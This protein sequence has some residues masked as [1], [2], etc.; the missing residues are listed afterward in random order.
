MIMKKVIV[1]GCPGG[2]KST[3]SRK[4]RDKTGLPLRHLDM[5]W[6]RP[7]K[8]NITREAFDQALEAILHTN[9]WIID[10][11]Y[12]CTMEKRIQMCDTVFF[13][14]LPTEVCLQGALSRLGVKRED[15]P[16]VEEKMDDEFSEFITNFANCER[17]QIYAI[18]EKYP[19]KSVV[20]FRSHAEIDQYLKQL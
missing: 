7:D 10:G 14:D 17:L 15:M 1:I 2:G 9:G 6:H 16:W 4:L 8:T 13:L 3:F 5:I 12:G 11:N 19:N 20:I 18:L